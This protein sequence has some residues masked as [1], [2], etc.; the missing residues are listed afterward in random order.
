MDTRTNLC[1]SDIQKILNELNSKLSANPISKMNYYFNP[2]EIKDIMTN[3]SNIFIKLQNISDNMCFYLGLYDRP[4]LIFIE[5]ESVNSNIKKR[6]FTC[7][8]NGT[9]QTYENEHERDFAGLY[10]GDFQN[11]LV[12]VVWKK[13]YTIINI[14]GIL[15]HEITHHFMKQH[16]IYQPDERENEIFTDISAIY[17]GFGHLLYP[18]YKQITYY[19]DRA[20]HK[21]TIGYITP[22]TILKA[23]SIVC[24]MKKWNSQEVIDLFDDDSDR[25]KIFLLLLKYRYKLLKNKLSFYL[26]R[27][28]SRRQDFKIHKVSLKLENIQ[29]GYEKIK[30]IMRDTSK[31]NN[32]NISKD[33]GEFLVNL[34]NDIFSL[35]TE[36]II[37]VNIGKVKDSK[38]ALREINKEIYNSTEQ[39]EKKINIWLVRLQKI[40]K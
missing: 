22:N 10:S 7:G 33:D 6:I 32:K 3:D 27:V 28:K 13:G 38:I 14:L 15:A 11:Q 29:D 26:T 21:R 37:K 4:R 35:N 20:T 12:M 23:I 9:I 2:I 36:E 5:E 1:N 39:L 24:E 16:N 18:A 31:F 8:P 30:I 17:L 34:T 40:I 19:K 25:F